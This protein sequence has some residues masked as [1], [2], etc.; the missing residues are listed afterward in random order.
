MTYMKSYLKNDTAK[1]ISKQ[2]RITHTVRREQNWIV[3]IR[4]L[5][6]GYS[7]LQM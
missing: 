1:V 5:P 4:Q 2:T 6:M 7:K 3:E